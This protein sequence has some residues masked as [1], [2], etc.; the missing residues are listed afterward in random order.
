MSK[1][2]SHLS[3]ALL[4][5]VVVLDN[6][7]ED[8]LLDVCSQAGTQGVHELL[9]FLLL[10]LGRIRLVDVGS[11]SLSEVECESEYLHGRVGIVKLLLELVTLLVHN[12]G[13]FDKN[14]ENHG[15]HDSVN[16][17]ESDTKDDLHVSARV[18]FDQSESKASLVHARPVAERDD[19]E[20]RFGVF[21]FSWHLEFWV[22]GFEDF[23]SVPHAR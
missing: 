21:T 7:A 16:D 20:A 5:G 17:I 15:I 3:S 4:N 14:T 9:E 2:Q 13:L 1:I 22:M 23:E 19:A 18:D 11:D 12:F 10:A 8:D 6:C